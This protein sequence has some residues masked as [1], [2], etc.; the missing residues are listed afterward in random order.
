MSAAPF[1]ISVGRGPADMATAREMFVEYQ[2]WLGVDLCFQ[3]FENEIAGLPGKYAPPGGEIFIARDGDAVAG[4]VAVRPVGA[5]AEKLSEMKRL[6]VRG[7]WRGR[8]LG[9]TLAD[10][11]VD[12]AKGAGCRKMVLDTL[13]QLEAARAMYDRMGFIETEPYYHNPISGVV[14]MEKNL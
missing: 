6:Y 9:R 11:A 12:F 2:E 4:I 1:D 13:P 14:Y 8:G 7:R 5:A 3:D 10:L